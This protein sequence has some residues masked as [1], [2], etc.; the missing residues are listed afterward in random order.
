MN[1][2]E[3]HFAGALNDFLSTDA[4][5]VHR[6][7]FKG[8]PAVKHLIEAVGVPHPEVGEIRI[9]GEIV[10]FTTQVQ[11]SDQVR[12]YPI[13]RSTG[14]HPEIDD[15]RTP[16]GKRFVLDTHLGKL[17]RSLRMLGFDAVYQNDLDDED[18]ARISSEQ[19]RLLLTRDQELLKR[20]IVSRGYWVRAISPRRQLTEI[21]ERFDLADHIRPFQRCIRCNTPLQPVS[22]AEI[23]DRLEPKT[24]RYY[25]DFHICPGCDQ[26]YW[27][28][29]HY[30]RMRGLIEDIIQK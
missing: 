7:Q 11:D 17:A 28:G 8:T 24:K 6:V 18:L 23:I 25:E 14:R 21:V 19:D 4:G 30:E 22:K 26:I 20:K 2:A 29:S 5:H 3:F 9:N 16:A 15:A 13:T 1:T 27:K 10:D 12:V